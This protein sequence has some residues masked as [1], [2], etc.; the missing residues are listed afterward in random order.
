MLKRLVISVCLATQA[1]CVQDS[2]MIRS[3]ANVSLTAESLE[4]SKIV[5]D[6][7]N[8]GIAFWLDKKNHSIQYAFLPAGQ[9][10]WID[11]KDLTSDSNVKAKGGPVVVINADNY[12]VV[13]WESQ[14][15]SSDSKPTNLY[16]IKFYSTKN[17]VKF[18]PVKQ[19]SP[20]DQKCSSPVACIQAQNNG[21]NTIIAWKNEVGDYEVYTAFS[22]GSIDSDWSQQQKVATGSSNTGLDG[23]SISV[24]PIGYGILIWRDKPGGQGI[25]YSKNFSLTNSGV[26]F[27]QNAIQ[28]PSTA[29]APLGSQ[30]GGKVNMDAYGNAFCAWFFQM[31]GGNTR[32]MQYSTLP[33]G[34][35]S[36]APLKE[37]SSNP[38]FQTNNQQSM[39]FFGFGAVVWQERLIGEGDPVSLSMS[40][41][42]LDPKTGAVTVST[43]TT[44]PGGL[45]GP[46]V[47]V[48]NENNVVATWHNEN[49]NPY[50]VQLGFL[51]KG[52]TSITS[53]IKISKND[54]DSDSSYPY[55]SIVKPEFGGAIWSNREK[56]LIQA[57]PFTI[58][59]QTGDVASQSAVNGRVS[60]VVR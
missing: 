7:Y 29:V 32:K 45:S 55:I 47:F 20:D 60:Y 56:T 57:V 12:G 43:P 33:R 27:A 37:F 39:N 48:D 10:D 58:Y 23:L 9:S 26:S 40:T 35:T 3:Q 13:T 21:D 49:A 16:A 46:N 6:R 53:S 4:G 44:L 38:I 24:S 8:N 25:Y 59:N 5:F 18:G 19:V 41:F 30:N 22:D 51:P 1:F 36:W 34:A 42:K 15:S 54:V 14:V 11:Q 52:S 31:N 2:I 28:F 50:S 17:G